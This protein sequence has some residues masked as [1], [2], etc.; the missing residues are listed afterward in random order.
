MMTDAKD[1]NQ[2]PMDEYLKFALPRDGLNLTH[3]VILSEVKT[4]GDAVHI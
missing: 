4:R 3:G 1:N 2:N